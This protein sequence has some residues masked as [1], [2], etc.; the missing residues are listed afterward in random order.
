MRWLEDFMNNLTD[1]DWGWWPYV[2][3]RP[4]KDEEMDNKFLLR[5]TLYYTPVMGTI[6]VF[7]LLLMPQN[8]LF[9]IESRILSISVAMILMMVFFFIAYR[10]TFAFT[11]NKRARR[12]HKQK[13]SQKRLATDDESVDADALPVTTNLA[14]PTE[15]A[16]T[17]ISNRTE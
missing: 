10:L 12:L 8:R 1:K 17:F 6:Y 3:L 15:G 13:R 2:S 16:V 11:W 14:D 7:T 9:G 5:L 4:D